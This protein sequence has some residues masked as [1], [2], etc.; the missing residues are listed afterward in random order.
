[1]YDSTNTIW[2]KR[3]LKLAALGKGLTSPNPLV[4]A[5]LLNKNGELISEGFHHKAGMPHAEAMAFANAQSDPKGGSLYVTLE[6]CCHFGKTPPCV[7]KI[8]ESGVETVYISIEDPDQRVSGKGIQ[9][10][11]NA[12]IKVYV[13]L[14]ELEAK[15]INKPFIFRNLNGRSFGTLKWAMSIDGRVG[16]K[17]GES[18]WITNPS[19]RSRVHSLRAKFDAV[20]VGGNTLREDN[21]LLTSR[22]LKEVEPLRVVFTKSL[23]LPE[24]CNLWDLKMA[25]TIVVYDGTSANENLL[26]R[27]PP[28]IEVEKLTESN[29]R[30]LSKLLAERG[31]NN[32]LWEC[33]PKLATAA[34]KEECI[35][36]IITFIAPKILG[37]E[38]A[39]TPLSDLNFS[40]MDEVLNLKKQD[41]KFFKDDIYFKTLVR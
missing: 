11:K 26:K 17:S 4:G 20:I 12:G 41:I 19:S 15:E 5:V 29:P 28:F 9:L 40:K 39:M 36:E 13:G 32:V 30:V 1:M 6:P 21:P 2:M 25:K 31:C 7:Q 3:A 10:L 35:Q 18:K 23:N 8:I 38:N 37:G 27:I 33:G 24:K 22:G 16:L 34:L 14:C